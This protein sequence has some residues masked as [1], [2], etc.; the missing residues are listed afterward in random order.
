MRDGQAAGL[1]GFVIDITERK[2]SEGRQRRYQRVDAIRSMAGGVAHEFNNILGI[3]LGNAELALMDLPQNSI[4]TPQLEE[5]RT[6]SLRAKDV[7]A[8]ILALTRWSDQERKPIQIGLLVKEALKLLRSFIPRTV[9]LQSS[10]DAADDMVLANPAQIHQ[11][12]V[13]LCT[14]AV[15]AI[16]HPGGRIEVAADN[17][18]LDRVTAEEYPGLPP[19]RYLRLTMVDNGCGIDPRIIERIFD[20]YFHHP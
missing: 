1:R 18:A 20:P 12:L 10:F 6:A 4:A 5:I 13:N 3:I 8:Q 7:V 19:G 16:E 2:R 11:V 17:L 9:E 14:N 15:H